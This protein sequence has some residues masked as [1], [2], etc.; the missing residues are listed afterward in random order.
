MKEGID[1]K[2]APK[3]EFDVAYGHI[4]AKD[5][6]LAEQGFRDFLRKY[7]SDHLNPEAQYWLGESLFQ[8]QHYRDAADAFLTVTTK[9]ETTGKAPDSLLRLGQ[10]LAAMGEKE[11]A[12]ATFGTWLCW[13]LPTT[14]WRDARRLS[15]ST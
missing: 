5:Y 7:P 10:S 13:R 4:Q 2:P 8:R 15:R 14:R 1:A 9:Y 6:A 12:C 11:T 3:E